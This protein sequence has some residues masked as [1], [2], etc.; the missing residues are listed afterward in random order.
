LE[1]L[2]VTIEHYETVLKGLREERNRILKQ[3]SVPIDYVEVEDRVHVLK[4]V[5]K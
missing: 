2:T 5:L 3:S 1:A 4:E